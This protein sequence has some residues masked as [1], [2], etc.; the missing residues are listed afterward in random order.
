MRKIFELHGV[1]GVDG[2]EGL[3]KDLKGVDNKL[4]LMSRNLKK[5]GR[6]FTK[7]GTG[8]TRNVTLPIVA[9][10]AAVTKAGAD[11]EKSM[12]TSLAI[13]GDVSDE[14]RT[15]MADAAKEVST[16]TGQSASDAAK[17]YYY[18][19]SAGKDAAQSVA[20]M[21]RVASFAAAGQFDL[22]IATDLLTDAQSALGMAFE[23]V[24]EDEKALVRVSDVLVK[25]NTLANASVQQFSEALT[26]RAGAALRVLGKSV[27]EGIAVLAAYADQGTKGAEA[28]T[29]L[30]IV[31]RDLQKAAIKE[32]E[33]FKQAG[34]VV[35]DS[36]GEMRNMADIVGDLENLLAGMSDEQKKATISMLGFQEKSVA[37]LL[38]LIGTSDAIREYESSLRNAAGTTDEVAQKQL[39]NFWSQLNLIKNEIIKVAISLSESLL[40]VLKNDVLPIVKHMVSNIKSLADKFDSFD[41]STKKNILSTLGFVAA[42]GPMLFFLGRMITV[43]AGLRGAVLL[44]NAAF[45]SNP[46]GLVVTAI[47]G[48][49]GAYV[50]FRTA[51]GL[52]KNSQDELNDSIRTGIDLMEEQDEVI[53]KGNIKDL[54]ELILIYKALTTVDTSSVLGKDLIKRA[55]EF[56]RRLVAIVGTA[57]GWETKL[58]MAQKKLK[59]LLSPPEQDPEQNP[60]PKPDLTNAA[61]KERKAIAALV[62]EIDERIRAENDLEEAQL[63]RKNREYDENKIDAELKK[64]KGLLSA[65]N[66]L[67]GAKIARIKDTDERELAELKERQT[68]EKQIFQGSREELEVIQERHGVEM[69][70][71]VER[72][73]QRRI[74]AQKTSEEKLGQVGVDSIRQTYDVF[75]MFNENKMIALDNNYQRERENIENSQMLQEEK[76][77]ALENLDVKYEKKRK[78]IKKRQAIAD[79]AMGIFEVG[80][81]TAVAIMNAAKDFIW[82]LNLIV[83]AIMGALGAA[84]TIA[85]ASKPIPLANGGIA[86]S[87]DGGI[88]AQI[89]E[90][91]QDEAIV[92][93]KTGVKEIAAAIV[94]AIDQT[95]RLNLVAPTAAVSGGGNSPVYNTVWKI[96]TLVADDSGIK[97][98]ERRQARFRFHEAQRLGAAQ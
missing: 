29:Q 40:P 51:L 72:Q 84:Q 80:I 78:A 65:Y 6:D 17:A 70:D 41:N 64:N 67:E 36:A 21:P 9:L 34:V 5:V 66:D 30:G 13:M 82:P 26:N 35:Y 24:A 37:S 50:T 97:E 93:M 81:N 56:E 59:D 25:A 62:D 14:M 77:K 16:T 32:K 85:I 2:L 15:K 31:L 69:E 44:L 22:Q 90:G 12:S 10:G 43:V 71:L 53:T 96:G 74:E 87:T 58:A 19:A 73:S 54:K 57:G 95:G 91:G 33:A 98:L 60:S 47:A 3:K 86:R 1:L 83:G 46:I 18:L 79:K 11:F 39:Q 63:K 42:A 20:L 89:A 76:T 4:K 52:S 8:L 94:D 28:G 92:P 61:E 38:T 55:K 48:A 45:L 88:T 68:R 49:V 75:S 7:I 27:E 23:D